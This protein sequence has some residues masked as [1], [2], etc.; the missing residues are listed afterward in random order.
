MFGPH[1]RQS[2]EVNRQVFATAAV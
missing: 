1:D 2:A